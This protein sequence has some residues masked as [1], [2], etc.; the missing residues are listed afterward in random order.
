MGLSGRVSLLVPF[1]V[2]TTDA[3]VLAI[4]TS[5]RVGGVALSDPNG[6][7]YVERLSSERRHD[8]QLLPAI[9]RLFDAAG[10]RRGELAAVG[11][12]TGPGGFTG[13][14][15]AVSTAK[16]LAVALDAAVVAV[17]SALVAAESAPAGVA[18]EGPIVVALASKR[19]TIW[20]QILARTAG[21]WR[22]RGPGAILDAEALTFDGI[23]ALIGDRHLP[24]SVRRACAAAAVPV[25]EPAF[26]PAACLAITQRFL[27]AGERTDPLVLAPIYARPPEAVR[28]WR[29]KTTGGQRD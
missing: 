14:R 12:S 26:E 8:D 5:Q 11:V 21:E 6:R 19:E 10:A 20:A 18:G 1:S 22:P 24:G 27:A 16:M 15:I 13:L 17:P 2:M 28:L 23:Q 7:V 4:E 25:I 3:V 29:S 9:D